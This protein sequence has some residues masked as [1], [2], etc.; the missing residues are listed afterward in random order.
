MLSLRGSDSVGVAL[1]GGGGVAVCVTLGSDS[2]EGVT[3]LRGLLTLARSV[4]P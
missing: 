1:D 2:V 4:L 3:M